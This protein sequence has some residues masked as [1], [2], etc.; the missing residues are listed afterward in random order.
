VGTWG[1]G[2]FSN[3]LAED[4]KPMV[5]AIARLP[6]DGE[7]LTEV[8]VGEWSEVAKDSGRSLPEVPSRKACTR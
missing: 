7:R 6:L 2:L 3:D 4:L 5:A 1:P 8:V